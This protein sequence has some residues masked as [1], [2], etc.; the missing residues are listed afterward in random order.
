MDKKKAREFLAELSRLEEKYGMHLTTDY[1]EEID[2]DY[3]ESP[4]VSGIHSYLVVVDKEGFGLSVD[5]LL[6]EYFTCY[7]CDRNIDEERDF[8]NAHCEQKYNDREKRRKE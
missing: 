6:N 7:Y 2:Y 4:Y 5:D 1:E 8:C 3:E